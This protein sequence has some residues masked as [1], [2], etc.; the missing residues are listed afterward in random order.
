MQADK[1]KTNKIIF[2]PVKYNKSVNIPEKY[3]K[4]LPKRIALFTTIQF[5]DS[6]DKIK[7]QLEKNRIKVIAKKSKNYY[8]HGKLTKESQLLGCNIEKFNEK[9]IDAFLYV[10]DGMFHPKALLIRNSRDVFVFNPTTNQLSKIPKE[11][12]NLIE[13]RKQ[14]GLYKFKTS[15]EIGVIISL[16]P[17]QNYYKDALKL[18]D[19]YPDK[20][21][22]FLISDTLDFNELSNFNL[23]ECFVNTCCPRIVYDD[24]SKFPRAV[25][26]LDDI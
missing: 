5:I 1:I 26:N 9:D 23:I 2:I 3:I 10:G 8:Y 14:I 6:I 15:K 17:G 13:K 11:E 22:Y 12:H 21:F 25:V 16:K 19:K 7:K 4:Q 18:K 24:F 20:N